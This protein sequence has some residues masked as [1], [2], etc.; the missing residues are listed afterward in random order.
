MEDVC[1]KTLEAPVCGSKHNLHD[2]QWIQTG[3]QRIHVDVRKMRLKE[4]LDF[5]CD[6]LYLLRQRLLWK[7]I[8]LALT[9]SLGPAFL[10]WRLLLFPEWLWLIMVRAIIV[11]GFIIGAAIAAAWKDWVVKMKREKWK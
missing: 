6:L 1:S 8:C 9:V 2:M 10:L 11:W 3:R 5:L 7:I 4:G